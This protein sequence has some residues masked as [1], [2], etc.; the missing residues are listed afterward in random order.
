[1]SGN[2]PD[3]VEKAGLE[4]VR[5]VVDV[6]RYERLVP[7]GERGEKTP[8]WRVWL[9]DGRIADVEVTTNPDRSRELVSG[10]GLCFFV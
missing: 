5:A 1:M 3:E 4:V 6:A 10:S 7:S 2:E 9:D 8:D